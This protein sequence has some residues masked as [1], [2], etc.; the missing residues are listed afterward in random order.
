M[1]DLLFYLGLST[2]IAHEM[3]AVIQSE[4]RLL[5]FLRKLP[6]QAAAASFVALHVPAFT[7]VLWLTHSTVP[8]IQFWARTDIALFLIIHAFLH[9]YLERH[10]YYSFDSLLSQSFIYGGGF[11]GLLYCAYVMV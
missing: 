11:I 10:Q 3:D 9:K 4:W 5:F 7:I 6:E 1:H 2:L 8:S